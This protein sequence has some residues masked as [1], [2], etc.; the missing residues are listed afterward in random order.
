M[1]TCSTPL[2]EQFGELHDRSETTMTGISIGDDGSKVVV[3]LNLIALFSGGGDSL[4]SLFTV[5]E[6][7]GKEQLIDF[8]GHGI[9]WKAYRSLA[10][11]KSALFQGRIGITIG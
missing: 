4:F 7:L 10:A 9:L 5:V 11:E 8:I 6:Q 1:Y 2:D 3:V